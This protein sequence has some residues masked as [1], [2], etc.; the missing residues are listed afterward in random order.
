MENEVPQRGLPDYLVRHYRH[1]YLSA[2]GL[3]LFDRGP[4]INAILFGHYRRLLE[5]VLE[6]LDRPRRLLQLSCA[7]GSLTPRLLA[8]LPAD[9]ELH[10][11][12][13][14]PAQLALARGKGS[15]DQRLRACRM[16]AESLGYA[17]DSFDT[18]L[19]FFLLHELPATA[20]RRVLAE[21]LRVLRPGGRLLV[22][23]YAPAPWRH[24]FHRLRPLRGLLC[25]LE[26]FLE[27]FW[28]E[29]RHS[30][31]AEQAAFLGKVPREGYRRDWF[32]GLYRL[33]EW[34]ITPATASG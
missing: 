27:A 25:R 23:D 33:A 32:G 7:Y 26:P 17:E 5:G 22:A 19:I 3:R 4:V 28:S 24:P 34:R 30:L 21:A 18:V 13:V 1:A 29:D 10:L 9:S 15:G 16:N 11:C 6:R 2:W 31:L 12:D 14:V 20:R 8:A